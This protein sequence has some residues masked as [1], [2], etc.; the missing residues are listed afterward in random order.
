MTKSKKNTTGTKWYQ[1][2]FVKNL[3]LAAIIAILFLLVVILF[4]NLITRHGREQIVPDLTNCSVE[5]ATAIANEH[6]L[7]LEVTDSVYVKRMARGHVTRQRPAPGTAVKKNRMIRLT[8]NSVMP[9]LSTVPDLIGFSLRQAKT[10]LQSEGLNVGKLTYVPDMA[11]NNVLQQQYKGKDIEPGTRIESESA[12]DLVLGLNEY[13][14]TTFIPNL[15]GYRLTAAKD[16]LLDHFLNIGQIKFDET[17]LNYSDSLNAVV[18]RITPAPCDTLTYQM[19]TP[20]RLELTLDTEK[21][22]Q[23]QTVPVL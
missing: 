20:V 1:H 6:H 14:Q 7:R 19:G 13:D 10:E 3:L 17:V 4:L 5:E 18:Y 2:W 15:L 9:R 16:M 11:S 22:N 8:I 21:L 23:S 12:I